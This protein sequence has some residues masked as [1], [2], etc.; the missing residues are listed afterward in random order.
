[1]GDVEEI[2]ADAEEGAL[3]SRIWPRQAPARRPLSAMIEE[4][5]MCFPRTDLHAMALHSPLSTLQGE[6]C[7]PHVQL[8]YLL[9]GR[10]SGK[11]MAFG[12][13]QVLESLYFCC[14]ARTV[15]GVE[16]G[17]LPTLNFG[18]VK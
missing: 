10:S 13:F 1:M 2:E 7:V 11:S 9:G 15:F 17:C 18:S 8:H 4:G 14:S 6:P 5:K 16:Q 3:P 12:C